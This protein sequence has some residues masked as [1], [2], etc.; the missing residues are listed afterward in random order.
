MSS[1]LEL[2]SKLEELIGNRNVYFQPPASV[3]LSYP[4]VIYNIGNGDAKRADNMV[5]TFTNSYDLIFIYKKPN[6]EIIETVLAE[7]PMC[8][9]ASTYCSDNLNHYAFTLYF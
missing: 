8:R 2:Q 7:F 1:R 4:C 9:L 6:I 3:M 5:Y